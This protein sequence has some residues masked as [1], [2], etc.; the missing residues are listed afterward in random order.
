MVCTV[1]LGIAPALLKSQD[2][3]SVQDTPGM[4]CV[5][6]HYCAVTTC[7]VMLPWQGRSGQRCRSSE[8]V[9][10]WHDIRP[11]VQA[12]SC[13]SMQPKSGVCCERGPGLG[14]LG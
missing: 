13:A 10:V 4:V 1:L 7:S 14:R 12:P 3:L 11:G 6:R 8:E 2:G 5:C 9:A